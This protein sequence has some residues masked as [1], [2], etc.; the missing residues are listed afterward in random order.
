MTK[1]DFLKT[2][3]KESFYE[4]IP[5][6]LIGWMQRLIQQVSET[7]DPP[8]LQNP[9]QNPQQAPQNP[10]PAQAPHHYNRTPT[11]RQ[12]NLPMVQQE[13]REATIYSRD[14]QV[15]ITYRARYESSGFQ[16][17]DHDMQLSNEHTEGPCPILSVDGC[18]SCQF[19]VPVT[20]YTWSSKCAVK[21]WIEECVRQRGGNITEETMSL[22]EFQ[23]CM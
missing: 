17:Y 20:N 9:P 21:V 6:V 19:F 23:N 8:K 12:S 4:A 1:H 22:Q 2:E 3:L 14:Y 10:Q 18:A 15:Y 13:E 5:L 16:I 7:H 11:Y